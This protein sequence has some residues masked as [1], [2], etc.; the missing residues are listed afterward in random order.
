MSEDC[1]RC[2][3]TGTVHVRTYGGHDVDCGMCRGTGTTPAGPGPI[4]I[5]IDPIATAAR[6]HEAGQPHD[7]DDCASCVFDALAAALAALGAALA[8]AFRDLDS[9]FRAGQAARP[10]TG[11]PVRRQRRPRD[12]PSNTGIAARSRALD[13]STRNALRRL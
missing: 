6:L 11:P 12:H 5:P 9:A 8:H 3:G 4:V 1:E 2:E 10:T 7:A 13:L